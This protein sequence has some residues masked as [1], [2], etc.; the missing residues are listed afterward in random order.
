MQQH[1]VSRFS[2]KSPVP[3]PDSSL[4]LPSCFPYPSRSSL[5]IVYLDARF[6]FFFFFFL[7][8]LSYC[9]SFS[10]ELLVITTQRVAPCSFASAIFFHTVYANFVSAFSVLFGVVCISYLLLCNNTEGTLLLF[11]SVNSSDWIQWGVVRFSSL[12]TFCLQSASHRL[13]RG[14]WV[15][16]SR[17]SARPSIFLHAFSPLVC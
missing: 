5:I 10:S 17:M 2:L 7:Y 9:F 14:L 8:C 11:L 13:T 6:Y 12:V 16:S 3:A 1:G 15:T 4:L